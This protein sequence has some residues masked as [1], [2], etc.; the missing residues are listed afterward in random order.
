MIAA[1]VTAACWLEKRDRQ[2]T[3]N[4]G[5]RRENRGPTHS[6]PDVQKALDFRR[7]FHWG[8]PARGIKTMRFSAD[9]KVGVQLGQVAEITYKTNK[10]GEKAK[11]FTHDFEGPLPKLVMDVK[12]KRLHLVGGGYTVTADGITG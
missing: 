6:D 12:T 11:F 10:R 3:R 5:K 4:P 2:T 1:G 7:D 9:P 8:I